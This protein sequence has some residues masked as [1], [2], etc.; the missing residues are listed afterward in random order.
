MGFGKKEKLKIRKKGIVYEFQNCIPQNKDNDVCIKNDVISFKY[1]KMILRRSSVFSSILNDCQESYIPL[2]DDPVHFNLLL[3]ILYAPECAIGFIDS[4][5]FYDMYMLMDKYDIHFIDDDIMNKCLD[6]YDIGYKS[7][8]LVAFYDD[9]HDTMYITK[10]ATRYLNSS[11]SIV[12]DIDQLNDDF[13]VRCLPVVTTIYAYQLPNF[14][15]KILNQIKCRYIKTAF[16]HLITENEKL[17]TK[18]SSR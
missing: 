11:V 9:T 5:N 10:M 14:R 17:Q 1:S 2:V 16:D 4:N 12:S 8:T 3:N 15:T 7:F 13:W 6:V 18:L